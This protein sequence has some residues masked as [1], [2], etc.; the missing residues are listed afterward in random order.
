MKLNF[1][2]IKAITTGA[3]AVTEE[4]DG[5]HFFRFTKPQAEVVQKRNEGFRNRVFCTS[6]ITLWFKTNSDFLNIKILNLRGGV[7]RKSFN[8][9]ICINGKLYETLDNCGDESMFGEY[10]K[11]VTL[12]EG[13]KTVRIYLP[14]QVNTVIRELEISDNAYVI[15]LKHSKKLV[16][17]GDSITHG[18]NAWHPSK[19]YITKL[20]EYLDAEEFNK[21][22]GGDTFAPAL[23]KEKDDF[24]PD[25]IT[26]A[27]GTNDWN[28]HTK[29][30]FTEC[31]N[32]FFENLSANYPTTKIYA[33]TPIWR[34]DM[35][36]ERKFEFSYTEEA[37]REAVKGISNVT[38]ISGMTL[39]PH[40]EKYFGDK[41]LHPNDEGFEHYFGNLSKSI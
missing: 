38:V 29:E 18:A 33:I 22:I 25:Y 6:G 12:P 17:Y 11:T 1:S 39:V 27:Y 4:C 23:A 8:I 9:D 35:H 5:I 16:A 19:K 40:E 41:R 32:S 3:V 31:C 28:C 37:I 36:D 34:K 30:F 7:N 20:A 26:V 15:P 13:E 14:W 10:E 24:V 2:Q 21:A